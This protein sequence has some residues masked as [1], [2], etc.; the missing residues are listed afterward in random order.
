MAERRLIFF[1][2]NELI[3]KVKAL[4]EMENVSMPEG[5]FDIVGVVTKFEIDQDRD[6]AYF[7]VRILADK[8]ENYTENYNS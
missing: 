3:D 6:I 2:N 7:A 5:D 8:T 1:D 4:P